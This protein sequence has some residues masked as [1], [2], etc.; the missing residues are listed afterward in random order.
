MRSP[1]WSSVM[2]LSVRLS[3]CKFW[4]CAADQAERGVRQAEEAARAGIAPGAVRRSGTSAR[5]SAGPPGRPGPAPSTP[6]RPSPARSPPCGGSLCRPV[7]HWYD[8]VAAVVADQR[9]DEDELVRHLGD[10]REVLADV[11]A[12]DVGVDR[13]ELAADVGRGVRFEVPHVDVRRPAGQVDVDDRLVRRADAGLGLGAR[14]G[15]AA[16]GRRRPA[17]RRR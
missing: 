12:G 8:V 17:C 2:P 16:P 10:A 3:A 7:M 4:P 6:T 1:S 11:D 5:R 13:L 9:A 15:S 14:A